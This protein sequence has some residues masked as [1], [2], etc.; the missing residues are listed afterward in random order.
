MKI[1][2]N[3]KNNFTVIGNQYFQ[4]LSMKGLALYLYLLSRPD[5]WHFSREGTAR[6]TGWGETEVSTA[7]KELERK[8]LLVRIKS[9]TQL[10]QWDWSFELNSEINLDKPTVDE[11]VLENPTVVESTLGNPTIYK[12]RNKQEFTNKNLLT[13]T[14]TEKTI[15]NFKYLPSEHFTNHPEEYQRFKEK[16]RES[17]PTISDAYISDGVQIVDEYL[18]T[19]PK[20]KYINL[21]AVFKKWVL[22]TLMQSAKAKIDLATSQKRLTGGQFK[23]EQEEIFSIQTK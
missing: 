19:H 20:D 11:P 5:D 7:G 6:D 3:F 23:R 8:G 13:N 22:K 10:G 17:V 9:R 1:K 12:E 15:F 2:K 4:E 16:I 18:M 21:V 14:N